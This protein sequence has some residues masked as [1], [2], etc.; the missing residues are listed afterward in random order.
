MDPKPPAPTRRVYRIRDRRPPV[1]LTVQQAITQNAALAPI[2]AASI[3]HLYPA[4]IECTCA[5]KDMPF[6]RCCKVAGL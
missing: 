1:K 2:L 3:A 4:E 5:A 6:G